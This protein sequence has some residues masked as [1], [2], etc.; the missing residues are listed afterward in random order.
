LLGKRNRLRNRLAAI[1]QGIHQCFSCRHFVFLRLIRRDASIS[2]RAN[3]TKG[4]SS[5][6][7]ITVKITLSIVLSIVEKVRSGLSGRGAFPPCCMIP[8]YQTLVYL[9]SPKRIIFQQ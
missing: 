4:D 5:Q 7:T 1:L 8:L 2:S 3:S 9:S 6:S